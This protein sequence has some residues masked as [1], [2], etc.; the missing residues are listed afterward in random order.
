MTEISLRSTILETFQ[1][2]R[3]ILPN[4]KVF[5][6]AIVNYSARAQ[7]RIDLTVGVGYGDDLEHVERIG[8]D[9]RP[10]RSADAPPAS[11]PEL[12]F[13]GFGDSSIDFTVRFWVDFADADGLPRRA[14]GGHQGH[15]DGVRREGI[16]IPFPIRTLD[17]G[18]T[19]ASHA[20]GWQAGGPEA[21][22]RS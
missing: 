17:F 5:G 8:P 12:Y 4:A 10:R 16:T 19:A 14:V 22:L 18:P 21:R 3:V 6:D 2:Q 15:Q 1:G 13:T 20:R 9:G 7:R 11:P